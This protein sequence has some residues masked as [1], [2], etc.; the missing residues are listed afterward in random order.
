MNKR[1]LSA[2]IML[3]FVVM[4]G[5]QGKSIELFNGKNLKGWKVLNGTAEY[6]VE[7]GAIVGV[8]KMGTPNTFLATKKEYTNFILEYDMFLGSG[9]NSGVQIRSH[10]NKDYNDGRVHGLQVEAD[11][12]PRNWF[13]GL[14][15]EAR[16]GWRYP[17]EYNPEVK[18]AYKQGQWNKIK[19][20]AAGHHIATWVNGVNCTNLYEENIETGFIALQV[21]AIGGSKEKAGKEIKWR[22][23][24]LTEIP[25]DFSFE[26]TAPV[27]SFLKNELTLEEKS[28]GWTLLWDGKTTNGWR[29]AKLDEFPKKGWAVNDG[30]LSVQASGGAESEHGGDIV[31]TKPYKNFIL[32]VDFKFSQG[33]NSGIKYFVDT[34][35]NKGKG[36]AIGCEFQILDDQLHPDAKKGVDGNRT[37]SSLYD[38]IRGDA[39]EYIPS[40]YTKKYVNKNGWNRAR[41]VVDGAKVQHY[42]N[43]CK[44]V[45]YIRGTQQWRALVKYSKYKDWPNFGEAKE[46]LILLQDHGDE[47]HFKNIKIKELN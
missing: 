35:L 45:E 7:D 46:G 41:I 19:V 11:D 21:H 4:A 37:L 1:I 2:I 30:V 15:D 33:A 3:S 40:L 14:F 39:Q 34:D 12:S 31:T 5:A 29:G 6:H 44:M 32:E 8:S 10:S 17:L 36:S 20:I 18:K 13:G 24:K 16:L 38:L 9:L 42:L 23:I 26:T 27:I 28:K 25:E 43:G 22:N 47:V